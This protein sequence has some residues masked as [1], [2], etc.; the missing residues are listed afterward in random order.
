MPAPNR[1]V[2]P[3][4]FEDFDGEQFERLVFAYHL[5]SSRWQT[6]EWYGQVGGDLGRDIWGVRE[7]GAAVCIQCVNRSALTFE[8]GAGDLDKAVTGPE[9]RPAAFRFVCRATVSADMRDR[10]KAHAG[11][12]G[13]GTCEIWG[14]AE[15]EEYLRRDAESLL[16]RLVQ[17]VAFPDS[18]DDL[19]ALVELQTPFPSLVPMHIGER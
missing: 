11:A 9:G 16:L 6:L 10:I 12:L 17:G 15:F 4:H 5:R 13:I 8:K 19:K 7:N 3:V 2:Q 14:G 18:A 1:M